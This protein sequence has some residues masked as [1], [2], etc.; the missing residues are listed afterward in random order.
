MSGRRQI[1]SRQVQFSAS[2]SAISLRFVYFISVT[3]SVPFS[4]TQVASS[5]SRT[6]PLFKQ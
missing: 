6:V 2:V 3:S 1:A 5:L 4:T